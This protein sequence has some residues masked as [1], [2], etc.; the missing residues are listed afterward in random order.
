MALGLPV[1]AS[2]VGAN[3]DVV[4]DG[5]CGAL[6]RTQG[7][8]ENALET[9]IVDAKRR[10]KMGEAGRK[11]VEDTY[12]QQVQAPRLVKFLRDLATGPLRP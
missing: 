11:R 3:L 10:K 5:K 4:E 6:V 8:W 9:L 12:S 2:A 7:E 1:V